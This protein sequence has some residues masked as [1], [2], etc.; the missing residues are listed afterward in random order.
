MKHPQLFTAFRIALICLPA[1]FLLYLLRFW[2]WF[3][4]PLPTNAL[5][6]TTGVIF[7]I[8]LVGL[9]KFQFPR[10][11]FSS[12]WHLIAFVIFLVASTL[13]TAKLVQHLPLGRSVPLGI[14]KGWFMAPS[15][16]FL[17]LVSSFR[18]KK[19]LNLLIDTS[20]GI[21]SLTALVMV[22]QYL[23]G[24]FSD[25]M[26]T[27][28]H[29]LVWPYL[30]PLSGLG[31]SG[32]YPALFLAPFLTLATLRLVSLSETPKKALNP[33]F[34]GACILVLGLAI[35]FTKSYGSW[36][37]VIGATA[38]CSFF[39]LSGKRRWIGVPLV[40]VLLL[41]GLYLDQK[42]TEKF[43][44]TVDASEDVTISTSSER[45]NI[46]EVSLDLI[47]RDPVWGVGPGQFQRGFERQAPETLQRE[48]SRKEVNHALHPHNTFLMFWLSNGVLGLLSFL[49]LIAVWLIPLPR[50]WRWVLTAPL[51][52]Y[53]AHGMIDTFYWKNDLAYSFWFFGGL[54]VIA[55]NLNLVSGKVEH[56]IKVG[57]MLG[58]PTANIQL[59]LQLDKPYGVY[60]VNVQ[61][62]KMKKKGLLYYG[63]RKTEGLPEAIVCEITL[64]DFEGDL[65]D[66]KV[67]FNIGKLIR[68]PMQFASSEALKQQIEKDV[69][70]ARNI[71]S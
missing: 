10:P 4:Y 50:E 20:L 61:V 34:Y 5:E 41:A 57:R 47:K 48:V 12:R 58:F 25:V 51:L 29:R 38:L 46:W 39:T 33:L 27:Y 13:A 63:P 7:L 45:L 30:D 52:Y 35:Y 22:V 1:I 54:A 36:V 68:K 69:L 24:I 19:D 6:F 11:A 71:K 3:L 64:L 56:G 60:M 21:T 8:W 26:M 55:Q 28:D 16:Y 31:T 49:L 23:T 67:K 53:L 40:S 65:Y 2:V 70:I 32:N 9:W 62:D 44:F 18:G 42:N 43:Q 66:K 17:M 59:D 14:W 37:A 15:C